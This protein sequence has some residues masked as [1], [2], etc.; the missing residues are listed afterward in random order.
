MNLNLFPLINLKWHLSK[1]FLQFEIIFRKN[2][3]NYPDGNL[4][5]FPWRRDKSLSLTYSM[6]NWPWRDQFADGA[7]Q[8]TD[9]R[10]PN[11]VILYEIAI[12]NIN[13]YVYYKC[14]L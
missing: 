8:K 13:N 9:V 12:L 5:S 11:S 2:D 4:K 6:V 10:R 1:Y 7:T 3:E 14:S